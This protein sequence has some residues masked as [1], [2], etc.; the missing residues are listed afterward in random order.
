MSS[1]A[2]AIAFAF[3]SPSYKICDRALHL[4]QAGSG[5]LIILFTILQMLFDYSSFHDRV[6]VLIIVTNNMWSCLSVIRP[7]AESPSLY[8]F[9]GITFSLLDILIGFLYSAALIK[10]LTACNPKVVAPLTPDVPSNHAQEEFYAIESKE[11]P[12]DI[13]QHYIASENLLSS[14]SPALITTAPSRTSPIRPSTYLYSHRGSMST[15]QS[16]F[17]SGHHANI[18]KKPNPDEI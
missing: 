10:L 15:S 7:I 8:V 14:I 3:S 17:G 4:A 16:Q 11:D 12:D 2:F 18:I 5:I 1:I 13:V 6:M 9:F